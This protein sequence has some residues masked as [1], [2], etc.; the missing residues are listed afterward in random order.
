MCMV[1]WFETANILYVQ[2]L[3]ISS[4]NIP[5]GLAESGSAQIAEA[6]QILNCVNAWCRTLDFAP[7]CFC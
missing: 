7:F 4:F 1:V 3:I 2:Y 5:V 6:F